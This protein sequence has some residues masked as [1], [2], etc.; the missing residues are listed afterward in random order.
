[1][2]E[3]PEHLRAFDDVDKTRDLIYGN[4][5]G[6]LKNKFPYTDGK[7]RLE[8]HD[9]K[10]SGPQDYSW[11]K[12]KAAL[13][14]NRSLKTPIKGTWKLFDEGTGEQLDEKE[15]VVMDVPYYSHRG[16][17]IN[18]GNEYTVVNQSRLKPGMYTRTKQN[19]EHEAQFNV[20]PGT[21]RGFRIWMEPSTGIFRVNVGQA[22]IPAYQFLKTQ[23]VSDE[24]MRSTWGDSIYD[25]NVKKS[26]AQ[27]VSKLYKRF[28]GAKATADLSEQEKIDYLR[29][30]LAKSELD[31]RVVQ[32]TSGLEKTTNVTSALLLR[33]TGKLLNINRKQE[34]PDDR[35]APEFSNI[36]SVED[37]VKERIEKDAGGT[38]KTMLYNA[39]RDKNLKRVRRGA[40]NGYMNS[41]LLGSGLA[42]PIE[43]TNPFQIMDQ[44]SRIIKLGEGGIGSPETITDDARDVNNGQVGFID[45]I[46]G[47]ESDKV[48]IDVRASFKSFKGNDQQIYAEF[49]D[50]KGAKQYLKPEDMTGKVLAFPGQD[51]K[52]VKRPYAIKDGKM[53]K[54]TWKDVDYS[55]P[56]QAHMYFG[57]FN[58]TPLPTSFQPGRAFYASKYWSQ[59]LPLKNGEVPLVQS[60]VPGTDQSF[61][62]LYGRKTGGINTKVGGVIT[63]VTAA[64]VTVSDEEG[65]KHFYETVSDFPFNRITAISFSSNVKEGDVVKPGDMLAHSNFTDKKTG[66]FNMGANLKTAVV[67]YEGFT[68]EDAYAI[69]ES[70]AKKLTTERL[71]GFDKSTKGE[72]QVNKN[73]FMSVFAKKFSKEQYDSIGD[74]GVAK[75]GTV[76][77]KGDP[78]ILA[79]GA[80]VLGKE[81][82]KLGKLHKVLRNA[83]KDDSVVWESKFPGTVTDVGVTSSGV[84]VNVKTSS[85]AD[86]G[87]KLANLA[88]S[89][90]VIGKIIPDD[91][92]PR[93]PLN[94]EP[95]EMLLNP[96]VVLSRVSP[97]QLAEMQLAK[98]A[99][100]TGKPYVLPTEPPEEGWSAFAESELKKHGLKANNAVYD[101]VVG[102]DVENLGEGFMYIS[103][104][105]HLAEK[106]LS[107]R[108]NAGGYTGD[109]QPAKGGKTGAKRFSNMDIN[110]L[111]AH[112]APE[113]IKDGLL[114]RGN[115]NEDYWNAL[116]AGRPLPEPETPFIY[117]KFMSTLKAGG[118]NVRKEGDLLTIMPM[119]N[120]DVDRLS[121]GEIKNSR[122]VGIKGQNSAPGGLFDDAITGGSGGTKWGHV[123]LAEPMPN[124]V[125]EEP[126]RRVLGL[127]VKQFHDI[128]TGRE[129]LNGETGGKAI[130]KALGAID[131]DKQIEDYTNEV[132]NTRGARRDNAVK[133]LRY[134]SA[135]KKQNISP[136]DWVIDKVPIIPP[137]F[138]PI[139]QVG[140]MLKA[141]DM[142]GLYRDVIETNNSISDLRADLPEIELADEK[143]ALYKSVTA[144]FGLGEPITPD[145]VSK[146]WKGAIRQVIG[147][148]PKTGMFQSK[149]ISKTVDSVGRGVVVPNP[150]FDMDT[151]G[152]PESKAWTIYRPFIIRRLA[153]RGVPQVKATEMIEEKHKDAK[154]AM[155]EEMDK[156]PVII[157]RAPTWHKMNLLAFKPVLT[158][159]DA[160]QVS[161]LIVSGFNMDFD[162]DQANF[163]VPVSDKAVSQAWD[164]MTPSK[165]LFSINDLKSPQ[166]APSKEMA[167]GLYQLTQKPSDKP[168]VVFSSLKEA[169]KAFREGLIKANDPIVIKGK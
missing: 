114:I 35:D 158:D 164:K 42:A 51:P 157:D 111:L 75:T 115:K 166:H 110:A 133:A 148:S 80:K 16:T 84:K 168:P 59:Y 54:S 88:A 112:G 33:T 107:G 138:R 69:S 154:E 160:I 130:R 47:P 32:R 162:G 140:D 9:V 7:H 36:L 11:E 3:L 121:S 103:A 41:L 120:A 65:K 5:M 14:N 37:F 21:G 2:D 81:D 44:H 156:R 62:Q 15:E 89:K 119:T 30:T 1:M 8:L 124:P 127:K 85:P 40:L 83:H 19:G 132:K 155:L 100:K 86:V 77:H 165:N 91:E 134:L 67:P 145:G 22:N 142:N 151:V 66:A 144:A 143:L 113:V 28:A 46:A 117:N 74:N 57:G 53:V 61:A 167:M 106:K 90:G 99:K 13:I 63:K 150:T 169:K 146:R 20:K 126:I 24:E 109:M 49:L 18:N 105:H 76:V 98:V 23:G 141:S 163:H 71:F 10:F 78:I 147:T 82:E 92:M 70:A 45:P 38:A 93:D 101:P 135:A 137:A 118:V 123:T 39:R 17:I 94:D 153:R 96:M 73:K 43:E 26:D 72:N 64:G 34:S 136:T 87:D 4:V 161:P 102:R 79:M 27:A 139:S 122:T 129:E 6:A 55:V 95:Y 68:F 97:N 159:T 29:E 108:D 152:I 50:N 58:L 104:F 12:Q 60:Q 149:V 25:A 125:M 128:L 116:R 48:G 52:K 31:E 131:V 56:S